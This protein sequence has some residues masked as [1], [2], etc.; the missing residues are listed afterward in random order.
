MTSQERAAHFFRLEQE[1]RLKIRE[2]DEYLF[3][4][5][6]RQIDLR[7]RHYPKSMRAHYARY[8]TDLHR[9]MA[10]EDL[11]LQSL[12]GKQKLYLRLAQG[13]AV[14]PKPVAA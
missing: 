9:D 4:K 12:I 6:R 5:A 1:M 14:A 8:V 11:K 10:S 13:Y 2:R 3:E 7:I